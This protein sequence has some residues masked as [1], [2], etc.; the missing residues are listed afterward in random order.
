[1]SKP[2]E[3]IKKMLF[4][5]LIYSILHFFGIVTPMNITPTHKIH[6]LMNHIPL[7]AISIAVLF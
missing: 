7:I 6:Y 2:E 1:M 5:L 4:G 3:S